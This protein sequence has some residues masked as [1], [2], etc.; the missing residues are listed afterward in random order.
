MKISN[1]R[2]RREVLTDLGRTITAT[3]DIETGLVRRR[4]RHALVRRDPTGRWFFPRDNKFLRPK[5]NEYCE[6]Q[7]FIEEQSRNK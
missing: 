1:F 6:K 5:A 3:V 4:L 2:D 7:N